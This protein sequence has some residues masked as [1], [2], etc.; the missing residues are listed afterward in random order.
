M[1]LLEKK[2]NNLR[3]NKKF[4][5]QTIIIFVRNTVQMQ[6]TLVK[7]RIILIRTNKY[8]FER[9]NIRSNEQLFVRTKL[10][11]GSSEKRSS[12][13]EYFFF[14]SFYCRYTSVLTRICFHLYTGCCQF[15]FDAPV[16]KPLFLV[17]YI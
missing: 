3:S 17:L 13:N 10:H 8:S 7:R 12:L 14:T 4:F 15:Y 1:D 2:G 9:T 11:L 16:F 5:F 6:T